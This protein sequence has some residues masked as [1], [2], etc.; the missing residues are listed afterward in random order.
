M[1]RAVVL[2]APLRLGEAG[3]HLLNT[4]ARTTLE[5]LVRP[6][7]SSS[8]PCSN[9][10]TAI[11]NV[12]GSASCRRTSTSGVATPR[13][14]VWKMSDA[15]VTPTLNKLND[16][17]LRAPNT[18]KPNTA[19]LAKAFTGYPWT[20]DTEILAKPLPRILISQVKPRNALQLQD[21][22]YEDSLAEYPR[23]SVGEPIKDLF[24]HDDIQTLKA[25]QLKRT[26]NRGADTIDEYIEYARIGES[27]RHGLGE[28]DPW[29]ESLLVVKQRFTD[30]GEARIC[31]GHAQTVRTGCMTN[32]I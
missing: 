2:P 3:H 1:R 23:T 31:L 26:Q 28:G 10:S 32:S 30:M 20:P 29:L 7:V 11:L 9:L 17:L 24:G 4:S 25:S 12:S 15:E 18:R 19:E 13:T 6:S 22:A 5:P 14:T 27:S 16:P 8:G 21:L